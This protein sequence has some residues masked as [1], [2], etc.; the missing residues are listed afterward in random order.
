MYSEQY[1]A[2]YEARL[3]EEDS[4]HSLPASSHRVAV[5]DYLHKFVTHLHRSIIERNVAKLE[6]IYLTDYQNYSEKYYKNSPWPAAEL[7]APLIN[8]D[9][10]TVILY[11]E[12]YFR[13][14][15]GKCEVSLENRIESWKN[16]GD[17]F[18]FLINMPKDRN[19]E[20]PTQWMWDIVDEFIYQFQ[21][22]CQYRG[23]LKG[24]S[25]EEITI[26][27]NNP[28][29][30]NV[31]SV[32]NYL[33]SLILKS[34]INEALEKEKLGIEGDTSSL[35]PLWRGFGYFSLL[36][37]LRLHC[38]LGDYFLALK[39]IEH[40]LLFSK[41]PF[42]EFPSVTAS[43]S[44]YS[45]FAY[46]MQRRYV[47]SI[48]VF[49]SALSL[50]SKKTNF[51]SR[52]HSEEKTTGLHVDEVSKRMEQMYSLLAIC[53]SLC[54]QR[55]D[56]NVHTTLR[57]KYNDKIMRMQRGEE[58]A[59]E[60]SFSFSCPKFIFPFAPNYAQVLED[61]VKFPPQN[62]NQDALKMQTKIF[63]TEVK[64]Q[65]LVPTIRSYL[66]LYTTI[67]TKKL[68]D[69]LQVSDIKNL[70]TLLMCY[71]HKARSL[72]WDMGSPLAGEWTSTSDIDFYVD[73]DMVHIQDSK[74]TRR[75]TEFFIR[76][77]NRFDEIINSI[78][79]KK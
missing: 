46:M 42:S 19:L 5:P 44:Y 12:L 29:V 43:L 27:K 56:E 76:H 62:Y 71:K 37:L 70:R 28:H 14:L 9:A 75:Y 78:Q 16:Y 38:L 58:K 72:I 45:G 54:P 24:K 53:L 52:S 26:L 33:Q 22:F 8:H 34:K 68:A 60:E 65:I 36:G 25:P 40:I 20:L 7:I 15:Y 31:S 51:P 1:D 69:F 35:P 79:K 48:K 41:G 57:E 18:H 47:D 23:K 13:H 74:V 66:K 4:L 73:K 11:K 30:W 77:I 61:P 59:F 49:S 64:Q 32:I 55:V 2:E 39:T 6:G 67:E 21:V 3:E 63:M 50:L 10:L 17:I